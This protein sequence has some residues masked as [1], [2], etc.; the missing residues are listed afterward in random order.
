MA[1]P[2]DPGGPFAS[3][4]Y[5]LWKAALR[6][7]AAVK[8][9]LEPHGL[10]ATQFFVLGAAGWLSRNDRDPPKQRALAELAGV[11][12]MTVSQVVRVLEQA[13]W[14]RRVADPDDARSWRV[15]ATEPG[16]ELLRAAAARVRATDREFFGTLDD[17]GELTHALARLS[18]ARDHD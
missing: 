2:R 15:S 5:H 10:T 7:K 13:G 18:E 11:D 1:E 3:P 6:W 14:V 17:D 9:A 4:G 8:L 16:R 12:L